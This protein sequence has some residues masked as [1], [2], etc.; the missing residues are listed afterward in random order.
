MRVLVTGCNGRVGKRMV[1][2]LIRNGHDVVGYDMSP[3][4]DSRITFVKGT[5]ADEDAL[6]RATDNVDAV[7]HLGAMMSWQEKDVGALFTANVIGTVNILKTVSKKG[8]K[9]FVL[10]STGETYPET[11]PL[12]LPVDELH[13]TQPTSYYGLTKK[14]A[15]ETV[16]F[17]SGKFD[18]PTVVLRFAHT[19]DAVELVNPESIFSGPRFYL[20]SKIRELEQNDSKEALAVLKPYDDG[21]DKLVISRDMNGRPYKMC[22]CDTR[23]LVQGIMLGL[24]HPNA[25][26]ETIAIGP[27]EE[28]TYDY[29]VEKLH[30][31]T[32][33]EIVDVQFPGE[34]LYYMTSNAKAKTLLGFR[35]EWTFERMVED[36]IKQLSDSQK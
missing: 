3:N 9:R 29:I 16:W 14:L 15:E 5:F 21:T 11:R 7:L 13:P 8:I 33:M 22:I 27:D 10:A 35:P 20:K 24:T 6:D 23:D 25:V 1:N 17:Y 36:G 34:P 4:S 28:L 30:E 12:Y 18:I 26:G 32:G 31:A 19:Q 2:E